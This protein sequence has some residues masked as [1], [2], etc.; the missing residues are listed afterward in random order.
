M[1]K[2]LLPDHLQ[3]LMRR[4][5]K[6]RTRRVPARWLQPVFET[7][8][9]RAMLATLGLGDIVFTGY[10]ATTTDKVSFVLLKSI[11]SGTVLTITDNAW[12]GSA[13]TT[14]EGNSVITFGGTFVAGTQV[15]YD[16]SRSAGA[17]WAVG[18]STTNISDATGGGFALNAVGDNLFAYNGSTAPTS[19][20]SSAWVS[21]F[22]SSSFL[23]SGAHSASLTY[24]PSALAAATTSFS[25]GL[26]N[27]AS[28][29]N[30][31]Y[32]GSSVTGTAAQIQN[33]V[34]TLGN[35][36][37][38]TSAG[39][40]PIP[41]GANFTVQITGNNAPTGLALSNS[42]IQENAGTNALVGSLSTSDPDVG[43]AFTYTLV[44][45]VGS[46][47][48]A[49]FNISGNLLRATGTLDFETKS[50]YSVRI[51]TTDQGSLFFEQSFTIQVI[52]INETINLRLNELKVNPPG[53]TPEGDKFQYI[54]LLGSAGLAL[55]N[56]YLVMLDGNG[57]TSGTADYVIN[58]STHA[59]GSNGLLVIKSPTGGHSAPPG[60]TVVSDPMFDQL[61]GALSKQTV[62]FYLVNA[63]SPF[64]QGSDYDQS[65]DGVIDSLPAGFA[66]ID[67]VGWSD[68]DVGDIV[69]GGVALTQTQGTPDAAT[70][71]VG[72]TSIAV[73]AWFNGDLE[74]TGNVP[75]QLDYDPARGSSNLPVSPTVAS[76]TPGEANFVDPAATATN[77]RLVTY[78]VTAGTE[79]NM[80]RPGLD[81][82]LQAIGTE[83]VGGISRPIDL[84]AMQEVYSQAN[85]SAAVASMLNGIYGSS[86]YA[87]GTLNGD[88]TGSG[89]LGVVF[90]TLT[91]QLLGETT[92]GFTSINGQPRQTMRYNFQPIGGGSS[93]D[94]YLYVSH[95][96]SADD[97]EGRDRRQVEAQ[98]I[99]ANA[100]ALGPG[101]NIIYVGDYNLYS[102]SEPAFQTMIGAGSG[103]AHDPINR[104]G[105]WSDN[106]SFID[107]FTQAPAVSPPSGLVGGGL[108]D[109][110]DFQLISGELTDG[111][112]LDYRPGSYR[113]FGNNGSV[114]MNSNINSPSSTALS[115]LANRTTVLDLLTTVSD[116]LPVVADYMLTAALMVNQP[117]AG[118][119]NTVS[120]DQNIPYQL[121]VGDFGFSDL[122]NSPAHL[123]D[124]VVIGTLPTAGLLTLGGL[125]V[126][127]GQSIP[128]SSITAGEL[129]FIPA[130][131]GTGS[132]YATF[133]FQVRDNGGTANGGVN[134]D[135]SPNALT[136]NVD[137]VI[138][139]A[140][141]INE[142][143]INPSDADDAREF[144][145][146]IRLTPTQSLEDVWLI[147]LETDSPTARGT[148]DFAMPLAAA[149]FGSN[150]LLLIGENYETST[151]YSIPPQTG[152]FSLNR[153]LSPRIENSANLKLVY[154]FTGIV[155]TD[156]DVNNNGILDSLPWVAVID[157][158]ALAASDEPDYISGSKVL[159]QGG[160]GVVDAVVRFP[161]NSSPSSSAAWYGGEILDTGDAALDLQFQAAP[162]RSSN[163]PSGGILTPGSPNVPQPSAQIVAQ[164]V[165]HAGSSFDQPGNLQNALDTGKQ[166]AKEGTA[167]QL[168]GMNN[169]INTTRGIN[170]LVFDIANVPGTLTTADFEFQMSPQFTFDQVLNPPSGWVAAPAPIVPPTLTP[171]APS[172]VVIQWT[173]N[174]IANR[175][176]RVTVK[177]NANTGLAASEV[178]YIGHL[179]GETTGGDG[180]VFSISF[181]SDL[182]PIRA[183][184][185]QN[186]DASSTVDIDKNELIQVADIIAMRTNTAKQLTQITIPAAGGGG[187]GMVAEV[188]TEL[189]EILGAPNQI[190]SSLSLINEPAEVGPASTTRR[191]ARSSPLVNYFAVKSTEEEVT[192]QH[193]KQWQCHVESLIVSAGD[194]SESSSYRPIADQLA[195]DR[196]QLQPLG[197]KKLPG[198]TGSLLRAK[199]VDRFFGELES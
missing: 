162:N 31:T 7:L 183:A 43:N 72:N 195:S 107:V 125:P 69:Y 78:N 158:V 38:F 23:T 21:A 190:A 178:Y 56:T 68:S 81:T 199:L 188:E 114:S 109:R 144:I 58:L 100:D 82:I 143:L 19:G 169:L 32:T 74:D 113:T 134:L 52:N 115:G 150:G 191:G 106:P 18:A 140:I 165:Y 60:T 176:L 33:V 39:S 97:P 166:L 62:T 47:D 112:G 177:A 123:F 8:E 160:T 117:P 35:W 182:I 122:N 22:A 26:A 156:Y 116:H 108:D 130:I 16:A 184:L 28:N 85:V 46:T 192:R 13:L 180:S 189:G 101:K 153:P 44:S 141:R 170:G 63:T 93:T 187:G 5:A 173:N 34:H 95:W 49:N 86:I 77:L 61:G 4:L 59:L 12:T 174:A 9:E 73:S 27:G 25:L 37:T 128:V 90:N 75:S 1:T 57:A 84:L 155:G 138:L 11:D 36:T 139:P 67:H 98:A 132:P 92:V 147:E 99:R 105:S 14:N 96:K 119:D 163:F 30:G 51:R 151:P 135:P 83:V 149:S 124:S 55:N 80:L 103:Q 45:G 161:G 42:T 66:I 167:P 127:Q 41:P 40:Q 194:W 142:A 159:N 126:A 64:V 15:N 102:S 88:T 2:T 179:L 53:G 10:Q 145:E 76:L 181:G 110:F 146:L 198:V 120:T 175:W 71:I 24:L 121:A 168:L 79:P 91:L 197:G 54:E 87:H 6:L 154:K 29:Q 70:R 185:A 157:A 171:G 136:I 148:V 20:T 152:R 118:T 186:V 94:F 196:M 48:N 3:S 137:P 193:L 50:S 17:K 111:L 172:R 129:V 65:N 104:L 89:T 164:Y 133:T 131:D